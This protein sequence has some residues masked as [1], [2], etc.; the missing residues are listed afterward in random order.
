MQHRLTRSRTE[1]VVSGVCGGLGEYFGVDPVIVRLIFVLVTL[2]TGLGL[3]VYPALWVATPLGAAPTPFTPLIGMSETPYVVQ[4]QREQVAT[5]ARYG[6]APP[7]S[8]YN[9]DPLTGERIRGDQGFHQ[10]GQSPIDIEGPEYIGSNDQSNS[11]VP[12]RRPQ[13]GRWFA[14]GVI[15]LGVL[16]LADQI[17]LNTDIV[18]PIIMIGIGVFLLRRR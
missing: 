12:A 13:V 11:E 1:K 9:Y 5:S 3:I 8:A 7:P 18:F 10:T 4:R 17:G 15:A 6:E 14:F 16:I 2:T